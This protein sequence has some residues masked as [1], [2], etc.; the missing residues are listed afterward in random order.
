MTMGDR[1]KPGAVKARGTVTG[2]SD[3][4]PGSAADQPLEENS[5]ADDRTRG[6]AVTD[7]D[8]SVNA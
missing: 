7:T 8:T 2:K 4:A 6:R 1:I 3:T 5:A